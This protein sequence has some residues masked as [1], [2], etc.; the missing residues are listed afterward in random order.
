MKTLFIVLLLGLATLANAQNPNS[1]AAKPDAN[2]SVV[3]STTAPAA[4]EYANVIYVRG[5]D[6]SLSALPRASVK[7]T[8]VLFPTDAPTI[9]GSL[10]VKLEGTGDPK[11][12]LEIGTGGK[13]FNKPVTF[14]AKPLGDRVFEL[15]LASESMGD[16]VVAFKATGFALPTELFAFRLGGAK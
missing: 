2:N 12:L 9:N 3:T 14:T 16:C 6:G 15:A 11:S 10:I 7:G 13:S 4:P 5:T 1:L 8:K